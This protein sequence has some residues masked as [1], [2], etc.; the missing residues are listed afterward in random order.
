LY[1]PTSCS[2]VP[3]GILNFNVTSELHTLS[4]WVIAFSLVCIIGS[5]MLLASKYKVA[6]GGVVTM[7]IGTLGFAAW[8][9]GLN[10]IV[11]RDQ[12]L[13]CGFSSVP[14]VTD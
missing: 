12:G 9:L 11:Y 3:P 4:A 13:A 6:A 7:A 10:A 5:L 8:T 14:P 1:K 2:T